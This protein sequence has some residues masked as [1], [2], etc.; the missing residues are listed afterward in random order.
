ML[1]E[2]PALITQSLMVPSESVL[3]VSG[4]WTP[5]CLLFSLTEM[6]ASDL[7]LSSES[8]SLSCAPIPVTEFFSSRKFCTIWGSC[9]VVTDTRIGDLCLRTAGCSRL[10]RLLRDQNVLTIDCD[11][12]APVIPACCFAGASILQRATVSRIHI[13]L[14]VDERHG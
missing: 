8:L 6:P 7:P 10:W 5:P 12:M 9:A 1:A 2:G 11:P 14:A 13:K 4:F 3:M